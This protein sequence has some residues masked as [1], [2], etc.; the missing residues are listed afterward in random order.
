MLSSFRKLIAWLSAIGLVIFLI[1][2][3]LVPPVELIL[4]RADSYQRA[5]EAGG[6]YQ[7]LPGWV[8]GQMMGAGNVLGA[9]QVQSATQA[10]LL[11]D[12]IKQQVDGAIQQVMDYL[13]FKSDRLDAQMDF[14]AAKARLG[15][16]QKALAQQIVSSWPDCSVQQLAG[17]ALALASGQQ[18][19]EGLLCN[20][21]E[22][23]R[24]AM[25]GLVGVSLQAFSAALPDQI[26]LMAQPGANLLA[27]Q[28]EAVYPAYRVGRTLMRLTPLAVLVLL[29]WL[30]LATLRSPRDM[31][32]FS[33]T[34]LVLSGAT[35]AVLAL[36][37][38]IFA[39]TLKME[40]GLTGLMEQ[41]L[42]LVGS[43]FGVWSLALG[44][45]AA[46]LGVTLTLVG[47]NLPEKAG[48]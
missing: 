2:A 17:L 20:P 38:L 31:L 35:V 3:L 45:A 36:A 8:A 10:V 13:N 22:A 19:K 11:K 27:Q 16:Q 6:F 30:V 5:L 12:E 18:P 15:Q 1:P 47:R 14:S 9:S 21:P 24:P 25:V 34:P 37:G 29:L 46:A 4:F 41:A 42:L 48:K 26:S 39:A 44:L 7:A 40:S 28:V 23:L 33:G 32:A 43:R